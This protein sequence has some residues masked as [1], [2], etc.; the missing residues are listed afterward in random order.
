MKILFLGTS[1]GA[2]KTTI[3]AMFCRYLKKN[4]VRVVPFKSSNLSSN[5][6]VTK[7]GR[8]IGKGQAFQAILSGLEPVADMNPVLIVPSDGGLQ[9]IVNGHPA[10]KTYGRDELLSIALEAF[11]RLAANYEAVVCEGSGSPAE[12]NLMERDIA[13]MRLAGERSIPVVLVGD[14]E[15]GGVF[16]GLYGTWKLIPEKDRGLMRGFIINRFRGDPSLLS[17][18]TDRITELT[19]MKYLG[20]MPLMDVNFPEEDSLSKSGRNAT[21]DQY[22]Q[23]MDEFLKVAEDALDLKEIRRIAEG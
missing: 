9:T 17:K 23:D 1:S 22:I 11:D 3:A 7:D 18:G 15:R 4:G 6:Y 21:Q 20:V 12:L 8:K 5:A 16:A 19:G 10:E 13:N 14:I 2:G